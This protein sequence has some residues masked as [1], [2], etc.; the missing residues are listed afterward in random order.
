MAT[1]LE[2]CQSMMR[3][4][5]ISGSIVSVTGQT[6]E[7]ARVVNWIARAYNEVQLERSD[8]EF[9]RA[10]VEFDTTAGTAS[11]TAAS[12]DV[13]SFGEWRFRSNG[14]RAYSAATGYAD[15][16]PVCYVPYDAFRNTYMYGTQRTAQG[17]PQAVTQKPDMSLMFW[18]VPDAA[19]SIVGEQYR[20]PYTFT[21]NADTPVFAARF[22]DVILWRAM[23]FYGEYEG[24]ST[25][26]TSAQAKCQ[27][28]LA[29]LEES[30]APEW[31]QSEPLA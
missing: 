28:M 21:A 16:Q 29:R 9:L 2:L 26:F 1:F 31:E 5:G 6:G 20:A 23:M 3:E 15:E 7:A 4:A 14:W 17:R 19:Y 22:H 27:S 8:W 25:V 18:P 13:A 30:Y 24:D 11:Y 12:A 10:D